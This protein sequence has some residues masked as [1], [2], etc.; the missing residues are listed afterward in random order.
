M[1]IQVRSVLSR[2]LV[3]S[4]LVVREEPHLRQVGTFIRVFIS[5]DGTIF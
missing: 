4:L 5:L 3:L 2:K 1:P